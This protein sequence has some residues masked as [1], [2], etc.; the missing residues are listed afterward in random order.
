MRELWTWTNL[1]LLFVLELMAFTAL[2]VWGW[3]FFDV[4]AVKV[5]AAVGVPLVAV[6]AWGLFAA[7]RATFDIPALALV[8]KVA[9]F[10]GAA[11]GL[12]AVGWRTAA[13]VFAVVLIA[14]LLAIRVGQLQP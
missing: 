11:V 2:G 1:T 9:V 7:P 8:T 13:V 5:I 3:K 6:V 12:W 4:T 10:G 14:N